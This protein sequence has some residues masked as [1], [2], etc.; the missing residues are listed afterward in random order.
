MQCTLNAVSHVF[1]FV[2]VLSGNLRR[3]ISDK[4]GGVLQTGSLQSTA[5]IQLLTVYG[6]GMIEGEISQVCKC[7]VCTVDV[8][9]VMSELLL[10]L[11]YHH[12][13]AAF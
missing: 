13:C 10:F 6:E 9:T 11:S 1:P 5:G 12:V 4:N 8:L 3:A 2:A 7:T